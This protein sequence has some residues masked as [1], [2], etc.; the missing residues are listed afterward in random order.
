MAKKDPT[1]VTGSRAPAAVSTDAHIAAKKATPA[2]A[3]VPRETVVK[4]APP[5]PAVKPQEKKPQTK[6]R[7]A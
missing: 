7:T 1:A 3:V 5:T 2:S 4:K 6:K